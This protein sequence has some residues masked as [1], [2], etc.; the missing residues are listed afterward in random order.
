VERNYKLI[1]LAVKFH[2]ALKNDRYELVLLCKE[3]ARDIPLMVY[4]IPLIFL[5]I[6][7]GLDVYNSLSD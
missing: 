6:S 5:M 4:K 2:V 7:K 1:F 3:K